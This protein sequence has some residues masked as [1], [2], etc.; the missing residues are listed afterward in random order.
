MRNH[1]PTESRL[2]ITYNMYLHCD[3]GSPA[4]LS[5]GDGRIGDPD[6]VIL[7]TPSSELVVLKQGLRPFR[8]LAPGG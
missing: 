3:R 5:P 2:F 4:E 1:L 8:S 6:F 7:E